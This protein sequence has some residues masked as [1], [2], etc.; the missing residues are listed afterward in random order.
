MKRP[1][2]LDMPREASPRRLAAYVKM[3][4]RHKANPSRVP[5]FRKPG[6][7]IQSMALRQYLRIARGHLA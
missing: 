7:T 5:Q 3:E 2:I 4:R 1:H 6:P